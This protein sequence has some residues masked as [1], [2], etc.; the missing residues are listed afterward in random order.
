MK[1]KHAK[2]AK[3]LMIV[4]LL[5]RLQRALVRGKFTT[6][7]VIARNEMTKQSILNI[8]ANRL[9]HRF[10]SRNGEQPNTQSGN[11]LIYILGA[12]F[13]LGLLV[14]LVKG[15]STPG[16]NID[17]ESLLIRVAE[18][19]AYGQELERA[20]A[21]IMRNGHSET[22]IR[23]AH[24]NADSAYGDI[25]DIPTRQVFSRDGGGASY[26]DPP[27][28]IQVTPTDWSF[29]G[30]NLVSGVGSTTV[31]KESV[32]LMAFLPYV[33]KD[34]CLEINKRVGITNAGDSPPQDTDQ[35]WLYYPF[36]GVFFY[37]TGILDTA[38]NY[39]F[40]KKEGCFEGDTAP[41]AGTYHYF[42]VLLAR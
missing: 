23:F 17:K 8:T 13:L 14:V 16:S 29:H 37:N 4:L 21:Y 42:R 10:A 20:V 31:N 19:Q 27:E 2:R 6:H 12:I 40:G 39:L 30:R 33:T 5:R 18:V 22:D 1:A 28:G 7:N 11:I 32:E 35:V 41:P 38:T 36:D 3:S 15:S 26:R 9:L 25:T 24:P 34:F